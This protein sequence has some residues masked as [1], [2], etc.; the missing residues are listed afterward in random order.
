MDELEQEGGLQARLVATAKG[1]GGRE[2][3]KA[4]F[5]AAD[6]LLRRVEPLIKGLYQE[7]A[8]KDYDLS[9]SDYAVQSAFGAGYKKALKDLYRL[10][11][12]EVT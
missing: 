5:A 11:Y 12:P 2:I 3:L 4:E 6:N 1:E 7:R 9:A 10:L 8:D